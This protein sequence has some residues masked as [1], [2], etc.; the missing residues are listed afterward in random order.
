M[1]FPCRLLLL[2]TNFIFLPLSLSLA[3]PLPLMD[4]CRRAARLA[5]GRERLQEI[6]SLPL[7]QSLKNYLQYQWLTPAEPTGSTR[8]Q[9]RDGW[10]KEITQKTERGCWMEECPHWEHHSS[11]KDGFIK[12]VERKM[13]DELT[14]AA[15]AIKQRTGQHQLLLDFQLLIHSSFDLK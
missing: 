6:E 11:T 4:L 10:T 7:P 12:R 1:F 15:Q 14:E 8:T 5:L 13:V 9:P 2:S 3:E